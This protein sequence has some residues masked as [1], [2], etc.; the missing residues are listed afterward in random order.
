MHGNSTMFETLTDTD[1]RNL[2]E[3]DIRDVWLTDS[4]ASRHI[5]FRR[6]WFSEFKSW[7]V[8]MVSLGDNGQC[9]VHDV[10]TILIK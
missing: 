2:L 3:K 7:K 8:G 9:E 10:G 6:E 1:I 5:T 4:G